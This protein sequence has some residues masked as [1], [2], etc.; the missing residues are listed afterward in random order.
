LAIEEEILEAIRPFVG[1]P[2]TEALVAEMVSAV[3]STIDRFFGPFELGDDGEL[4]PAKGSQLYV[5]NYD[6]FFENGVSDSA[7]RLAPP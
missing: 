1:R 3:E 2:H 6:V 4:Y 7:G 5:E